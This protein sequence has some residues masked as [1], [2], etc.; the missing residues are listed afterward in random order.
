MVTESVNCF[1]GGCG[2]NKRTCKNCIEKETC[3]GCKI[4]HTT[5]LQACPHCVISCEHEKTCVYRAEWI[6]SMESKKFPECDK[7][8][9]GYACAYGGVCPEDVIEDINSS[10]DGAISVS[11]ISSPAEDDKNSSK[12]KKRKGGHNGGVAVSSYR[13]PKIWDSGIS[14]ISDCPHKDGIDL[15]VALEVYLKIEYLQKE[16]TDVEFTVYGN[17]ILEEDGTYILKDIVIPKQMAGHSS[18][19]DIQCDSHYNTIIHKHPGE[20]PGGFSADDR[21]YAN[22][23]HDFSILIGSRGMNGVIGEARI[24]TECNKYMQVPLRVQV[25]LPKVTDS[26]FL[27]SVKNIEKKVYNTYASTEYYKHNRFY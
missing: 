1:D 11:V 21:E 13:K 8:P 17:S 7:C 10:K 2:N 14:C 15:R 22:K 25:E 9:Y 27:E 6:K 26:F 5:P 12:K 19:D 18:V 16:F 24:K 20:T 3:K 4:C 23:N